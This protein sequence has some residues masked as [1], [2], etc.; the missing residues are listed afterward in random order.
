MSSK[1]LYN[2]LN[3]LNNSI[4]YLWKRNGDIYTPNINTSSNL[5][6][7][8]IIDELNKIYVFLKIKEN[9]YIKKDTKMK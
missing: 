6:E 8:E 2:S 7:A 9:N 3:R 4:L 5:T 1:N